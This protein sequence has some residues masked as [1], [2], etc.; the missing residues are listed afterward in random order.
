LRGFFR[1]QLLTG[2]L[3]VLL[4]DLVGDGIHNGKLCERRT[5]AEKH[6]HDSETQQTFCHHDL[7]EK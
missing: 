4:D 2:G 1:P 5:R 7:D 6:S 3:L